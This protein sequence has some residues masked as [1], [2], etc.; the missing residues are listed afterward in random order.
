MQL[1]ISVYYILFLLCTI[2]IACL[3][4]LYYRKRQEHF[5]DMHGFPTWMNQ[6]QALIDGRGSIMI[7][8]NFPHTT[9]GCGDDCC[10]DSESDE[11][12][13]R[14]VM[15]PVPQCPAA[16]PP[17]NTPPPPP[18][19]VVSKPA[20]QRTSSS[21]VS[22]PRTSQSKPST[23][24]PSP[25]PARS[26]NK[27]APVS[28]IVSA[29]TVSGNGIYCAS[30]Q[31]VVC[32]VAIPAKP[33]LSINA[34]AITGVALESGVEFCDPSKSVVQSN[35]SDRPKLKE[36]THAGGSPLRFLKITGKEPLRIGERT[37]IAE[38]VLKNKDNKG[39]SI[40]ML[41]KFNKSEDMSTYAS[42]KD[43]PLLL[44]HT[45]SFKYYTD[46]SSCVMIIKTVR[47]NRDQDGMLVGSVNA[48]YVNLVEDDEVIHVRQSQQELTDIGLKDLVMMS[49][50]DADSLANM[51]VDLTYFAIYD[52][53]LN[54]AERV[55]IRNSVKHILD[56]G[57][58]TKYDLIT[59]AEYNFTTMDPKAL[60]INPNLR[61]VVQD[62]TQN[63]FN[64]VYNVEGENVDIQYRLG[65]TQTKCIELT[66]NEKLFS[67]SP[68]YIDLTTNGYS[69]E[70]LFCMKQFSD[71]NDS[72]LL[73]YSSSEFN[74]RQPQLLVG[75]SPRHRIH[76]DNKGARL[77]IFY[78]ND[79][80]RFECVV[81][82]QVSKWYHV[83]VTSE[84]KI[85]LNGQ[86]A[87]TLGRAVSYLPDMNR[88]LAIG[89]HRATDS[90]RV[91]SDH[92]NSINGYIALAKLYN[93]PMNIATASDKYNAL[94]GIDNNA[95]GI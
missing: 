85:F 15:P 51:D 83:I 40:V 86:Q 18:A 75:I 56:V 39:F 49:N 6:N 71:E 3:V 37:P 61:R 41:A 46:K 77:S 20:P 28:A 14:I 70:L 68:V 33:I 44:S 92:G 9:G 80:P 65:S 47:E 59:E 21:P 2:V 25:S 27:S 69:I 13:P 7:N 66:K 95:Y 93:S 67:P 87:P 34:F 57:A 79:L 64:L 23:T 94:K 91:S 1:G 43:T 88:I 5:H 84:S 4:F 24:T 62:A 52:R 63:R 29:P 22:A 38:K 42:V 8:Q 19:A 17:A 31:H 73:S 55:L 10:C 35:A 72:I 74:I 26:G 54:M 30:P 12:P 50:K 81:D 76:L 78:A 82:L 58:T 11:E 90:Y 48:L 32:E 45:E 53:P 16:A 89:D 36:I 60:E